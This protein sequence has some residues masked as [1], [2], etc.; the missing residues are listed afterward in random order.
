MRTSYEYYLGINFA[1]TILRTV[2]YF[3]I[4]P[5]LHVPFL[6][7]NSA[8][9]EILAL[10]SLNFVILW[11][12]AFFLH[13]RY[14]EILEFKS[15]SV[16]IQTLFCILTGST[17][18]TIIFEGFHPDYRRQGEAWVGVYIFVSEFVLLNQFIS[19]MCT[20]Y[21]IVQSKLGKGLVNMK[22]VRHLRRQVTKKLRAIHL[23]PKHK[24]KQKKHQSRLRRH[25][26]PMEAE[27]RTEQYHVMMKILKDLSLTVE[28]TR[29]DI[30]RQSRW[31]KD[32]KEQQQAQQLQ[33]ASP[34]SIE[35]LTAR[36]VSFGDAVEGA[37]AETKEEVEDQVEKFR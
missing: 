26:N 3:Q 23:Y 5:I 19:V 27:S 29:K 6:A 11:A 12:F 24:R 32:M 35:R 22:I 37:K 20:H 1:I 15:I 21:E 2:K 8:M 25:S 16:S 18:P 17:D 31:I 13:S 10:L 9:K 14:G 30:D 36:K 33:L 34:R 7:M 28:Q 4:S